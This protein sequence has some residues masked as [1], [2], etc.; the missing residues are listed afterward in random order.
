MNPV[1]RSLLV[2]LALTFLMDPAFLPEARAQDDDAEAATESWP[3]RIEK[4]GAGIEVYQPQPEVFE[5]N[6]LRV[7]CAVSVTPKGETEPVF[8]AVWFEARVKTDRDER[9]VSIEDIE[10]S[11]IRFPTAPAEK[12]ELLK[13]YITER[14]TRWDGAQISLDRL[15]TSLNEA[16]VR[17]AASK[18][19]ST[20]PPKMVF[21]TEPTELVIIDGEPELR[22]V[23]NS[24]V[25]K[26]LNSIFLVV[27]EPKS[28]AYFLN[29]GRIWMTAPELAGPWKL[30]KEPPADVAALTPKPDPEAEEE[31][32]GI[33]PAV[34]VVTEPMEMITS[35]GDPKYQVL[36]DKDLLFMSNTD[37]TVF[38]EL[39]TQDLYALV[40]GRWF[41]SKSTDGPWSYVAPDELPASFGKIPADS[42]VGDA[43]SFVAGTEEAKEA[44]LDAQIP[45]TQT[46]KRTETI[47]VTCDGEPKFEPIKETSMQYAVNTADSVIRATK[48]GKPVYYCC[49]EGVW[50]VSASPTGPYAVSTEAPPEIQSVPAE[51]PVYNTKYVTVYSSTPT[52]VYV[53]YTPGYHHCYVYGGTVVYGTGYTYR[54]WVGAVYY[55]RP[56]TYGYARVY[57]P[58]VGRWFSPYSVGGVVRRTRRR[59]RRRTHYRHNHRYDYRDNRRDLADNRR[60]AHRD[61]VDRKTDA[62]RD[63]MDRKTDRKK[64]EVDRKTDQNRDQKRNNAYADKSGNVHRKN[65]SGNWEKRGKDGWS[66]SDRKSSD[67]AER[68]QKSRERGTT[69]TNDYKRSS[70]SGSGSSRSGGRSGGGGRR[71]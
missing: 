22:P 58:G 55:P 4:D 47:T 11:D 34:M 36:P 49:R 14:L 43:R 66:S 53:G 5:G 6:R 12:V 63:Q 15:M 27:L 10:V 65:E 20:D 31:D 64:N 56:V 37:G 13:G 9:E 61:R 50:Y 18:D 62:K 23:E 16:E 48:D 30:S 24:P 70:S 52:V 59:T 57:Y 60:D 7:R 26:V 71:R 40:S 69:R 21:V 33:V 54:V 68:N 41:R 46:V 51:N 39:A 35:D 8:G 2:V 45:Q 32:E 28:K 1:R 67:S 38:R 17:I 19:L 42:D 3:R 25:M 44:V 29:L